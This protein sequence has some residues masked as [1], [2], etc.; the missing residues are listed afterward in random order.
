MIKLEKGS[1]ILIHDLAVLMAE[2]QTGEFGDFT[3]E[4]YPAPKVALREKLME[5]ADNVVKGKY[6]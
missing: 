4:K 5:L 2:A 1:E 3:N 6:D